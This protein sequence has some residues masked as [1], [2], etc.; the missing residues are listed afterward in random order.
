[1][2]KPCLSPAVPRRASVVAEGLAHVAIRTP[3]SRR[4]SEPK[5]ISSLR[6][7]QGLRRMEEQSVAAV[8]SVGNQG[9]LRFLM[10]ATLAQCGHPPQPIGGDAW[11]TALAPWLCRR[12]ER[13]ASAWPIQV[14]VDR[15][16]I[17]AAHSR[18]S[19]PAPSMGPS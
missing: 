3:A 12:F 19:S 5:E 16:R 4:V 10:R 11:A 17:V 13:C 8:R 9:E 18:N 15:W 2:I 7:P 1:M 6:I 14:S